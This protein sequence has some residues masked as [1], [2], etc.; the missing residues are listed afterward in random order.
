MNLK[1]EKEKMKKINLVGISGKIGAGKDTVAKIIQYLTDIDTNTD[2]TSFKDYLEYSTLIENK[3]EIKKFAGKLKDI[4]CLL[5]GCTRKQLEDQNFKNKKLGEEWWYYK[6]WRGSD[7]TEDFQE[8]IIPYPDMID[9]RKE[10]DEWDLI[11]PTVRTLLQNVGGEA[12]RGVIHPDIWI[13]ALFTDYVRPSHWE[14]RFYENT[15]RKVLAGREQVWGDLPNWIITDLRYPNEYAAIKDRD[16]ITIRVNRSQTFINDKGNKVV[17]N[18][19]LL[20]NFHYSETAL[21]DYPFDYVID[22]NGTIE[23]LI[24][25]VKTLLTKLKII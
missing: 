20:N 6:V 14:D 9:E 11:K 12:M 23:D 4:V 16:G 15:K 2:S 8:M 10:W 25:K 17:R 13:N 1:Q 7:I 21:D 24:Q 22:N 18:G 3:W 19:S 5:L